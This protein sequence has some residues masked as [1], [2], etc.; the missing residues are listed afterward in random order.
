MSAAVNS[1]ILQSIQ[2]ET[3]EAAGKAEAD[4]VKERQN[5][6]RVYFEIL[7]DPA[8]TSPKDKAAMAAAVAILGKTTNDAIDEAEAIQTAHELAAKGA[9][10]DKEHE[11]LAA[12]EA[13]LLEHHTAVKLE[14]QRQIVARQ[15]EKEA[16]VEAA[17]AALDEK[18]S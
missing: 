15:R 16:A 12:A 6:T 8:R 13:A 2:Q 10:P 17:K 5:A 3:R 14:M 11:A 4:R 18:L 1:G 9:N 7:R